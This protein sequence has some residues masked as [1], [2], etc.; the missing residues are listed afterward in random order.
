MFRRA[1][2]LGKPSPDAWELIDQARAAR[3]RGHTAQVLHLLSRAEE[4]AT[5]PEERI[6]IA[7]SKGATLRRMDR[8]TDAHDV[9]RAGIA[10]GA[11][12]GVH[13][14]IF[15]CL[16]ATLCDLDRLHDARQEIG[17]VI[18][19]NDSDPL[20]LRAGARIYRQSS[21]GTDAFRREELWCLTRLGELEA[22][23]D[24]TAVRLH[25]LA[26]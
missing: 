21:N 5:S 7:A 8:A 17:A 23:D 26:E 20:A 15:T 6:A 24:A 2:Q 19:E 22:L 3:G 13:P 12:R 14:Q 1:P 10:L 4:F 25:E 11:R 18:D 9:L 16:A